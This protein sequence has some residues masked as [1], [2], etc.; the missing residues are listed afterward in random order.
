M[1]PSHLLTIGP[2]PFAQGG[3]GDVYEGTLDGSKVCIKRV[4]VYV[5]EEENA[6]KVHHCCSFF[7]VRITNEAQSFYREAVTWKRLTHPNILHLL[8]I[9]TT[10]FQLVSNWMVGGDL[11]GYIKGNPDAER[12]GL[13]GVSLGV[14]IPCL[15]QSLAMRYH[16]G[17]LLPPFL[18]CDSRKPQGS[19]WLS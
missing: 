3:H 13:V 19:M 2:N 9:T 15:L 6:I 1:I 18:P 8:G 11:P 14:F 12:V 17:P 7:P 5:Q 10:P 4:R 16:Q